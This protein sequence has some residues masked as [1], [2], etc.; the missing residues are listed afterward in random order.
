M[1]TTYSPPKRSVSRRRLA[2]RG[3]ALALLSVGFIGAPS[4]VVAAKPAPR[5]AVLATPTVATIS[6][7]TTRTA[8]LNIGGST[9]KSYDVFL[10]GSIARVNVTSSASLAVQLV[11]MVPNT[12]YSVQVRERKDLNVSPL[13]KPFV[14]RTLTGVT[15]APISNLQVV[16]ATTDAITV[17]WDASPNQG[18]S[19]LV[20]LNGEP[21]RTTYL[22]QATLTTEGF[23]CY[24]GP[25][26]I[27]GPRPGL[28]TVSVET[29]AQ[30]EPYYYQ[31]SPT[32]VS[33]TVNV[34]S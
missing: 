21:S 27:P 30:T 5:P 11:D 29:T 18:A 13:S 6:Q 19:Y 26:T 20:R 2:F 31:T 12:S 24:P 3:V 9:A 4:A 1:I 16:S 17:A 23:S 34:P 22:T 8:L 28:N 10:N 7:I 25:C 33:I 14:F 15:V 32:I